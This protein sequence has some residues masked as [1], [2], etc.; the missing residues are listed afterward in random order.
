MG[1][2]VYWECC[3]HDQQ[4]ALYAYKAHRLSVALVLFPEVLVSTTVSWGLL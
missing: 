4:A 3:C 2:G 1:H